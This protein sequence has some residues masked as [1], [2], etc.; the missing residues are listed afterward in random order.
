MAFELA[1]ARQLKSPFALQPFELSPRELDQVVVL[2]ELKRRLPALLSE[3]ETEV[4]PVACP[5]PS[6]EETLNSPTA[7][8]ALVRVGSRTR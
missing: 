5:V 4:R 7:V 2:S 6:P 1:L 3:D 8:V